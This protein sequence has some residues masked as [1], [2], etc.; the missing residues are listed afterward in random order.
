MQ[1]QLP[2]RYH[3]PYGECP[4]TCYYQ[5]FLPYWF[6]WIRAEKQREM[7]RRWLR[8]FMWKKYMMKYHY[9]CQKQDSNQK[10]IQFGHRNRCCC[11]FRCCKINTQKENEEKKGD[12]KENDNKISSTLFFVQYTGLF[13]CRNIYLIYSIYS[14]NIN[15]CF[16]IE[17]NNEFLTILVRFKYG[18][19]IIMELL[20]YFLFKSNFHFMNFFHPFN[21]IKKFCL[22]FE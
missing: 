12:E 19:Y 3:S 1:T 6:W 9:Q 15:N 18:M 14:I 16:N 7:R 13:Q 4:K 8:W 22:F 17:L 20:F 10:E 5:G 2:Q 21:F 11:K